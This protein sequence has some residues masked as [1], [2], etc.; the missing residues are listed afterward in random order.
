MASIKRRKDRGNKWQARYR[1]HANKEHARLFDRKVD[2]ERWLDSIR[3]DLV[4]GT[5]IDPGAGRVSF[6]D[7]AREWQ[8]AQVQHRAATADL[9]GRHLKNHI[10]PAFE[11]RP[12]SSLKRS[13]VQA[14]VTALTDKLAPS[15]VE[16]I[17]GYCATI[18]RAA[19]DDGRI[20]STPCRNIN[21][22]KIEVAQVV[23][24][25]VDAVQAITAAMPERYKA[26][27]TLAAGTG[28]RQGECF[29]LTVGNVDFLRRTIRVAQQVTY[30]TPGEPKISPLKT[31][32]SYR[33]VP[34]PDVVVEALAEHLAAHPAGESGLIFT[35]KD[36]GLLRR[37]RFGEVW[38][39]AV[40]R[41]KLPEGTHFHELRHFYASLLIH[42]GASVKVVQARLGHKS[43][44]ETLDTYGHLWPD[45][46][47]ATR[48]AIDAALGTLA[49]Q[50][51][52]NE[53]AAGQTS[54]SDDVAT[55]SRPVGGETNT[56]DS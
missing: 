44:T 1:D 31:K 24:L 12:L 28:L 32:A 35:D 6:G 50:T 20:A 37:T 3:G 22:P 55:V 9:V 25:P 56:H 46:E 2:A 11:D 21:L 33:T 54:R 14:W 4:R 47:D 29:G 30:V 18:F 45:S 7:Y 51:R 52:T 40:K 13:D 53:V 10:L 41:A 19:M 49:D 39:A 8:A 48:T 26:M 17:Y 42:S 34:A 43:A 38:R 36:G 5:Y 27:V 23:P 16:L 15:T